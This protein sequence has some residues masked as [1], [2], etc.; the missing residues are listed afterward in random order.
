MSYKEGQRYATT[1]E[2]KSEFGDFRYN[3][4]TENLCESKNYEVAP[5]MADADS[6]DTVVEQY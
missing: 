3:Y 6:T 4:K 1:D 5:S 2:M